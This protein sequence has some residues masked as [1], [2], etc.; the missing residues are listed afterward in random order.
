MQ[1]SSSGVLPVLGLLACAAAAGVFAAHKWP[2][3][4]PSELSHEAWRWLCKELMPARPASIPERPDY[5]P[6]PKFT[7]PS[8][9][10]SNL[11]APDSLAPPLVVFDEPRLMPSD[12]GEASRQPGPPS[13]VLPHE[14]SPA[15]L[16]PASAS[17]QTSERNDQKS[18]PAGEAPK[19]SAFWPSDLAALLPGVGAVDSKVG[20]SSPAATV[21]AA[22]PSEPKVEELMR[23]LEQ[24]GAVVMRLERQRGAPGSYLFRCELP[25][26][27]NP[28]YNRFFQAVDAQPARAVERVARDVEAWKATLR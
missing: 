14:A 6:A 21:G 28:R 16:R 19:T 8:V 15:A 1:S 7:A 26:P 3:G 9:D 18:R 24:M 12:P 10:E 17:S 4:P 2:Q 22:P 11:V 27:Q 23:R 25:L 13:V 5:G 20:A